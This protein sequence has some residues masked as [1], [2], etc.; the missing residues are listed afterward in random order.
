M[1]GPRSEVLVAVL[2]GSVA[3]DSVAY[4]CLGGGLLSVV[5][6]KSNAKSIRARTSS[7]GLF[8]CTC[9]VSPAHYVYPQDT[10]RLACTDRQRDSPQACCVGFHGGGGVR[11][12]D[13]G[14]KGGG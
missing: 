8:P 6:N 1:V 7:R 13:G 3:A 9:L 4:C 2:N 5:P 11:G 14:G 10:A 12:G